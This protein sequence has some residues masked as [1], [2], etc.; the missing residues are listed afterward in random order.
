MKIKSY[1]ART[2]EAAMA[3]ARQELG[4]DAQVGYHGHNNL[5]MGVANSVLAYRAGAR[6]IDGS[7]RA[8]GA[9]AGYASAAE[10]QIG[11]WIAAPA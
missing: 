5:A 2:V 9:G 4:D 7:A 11:A 6:Q 8:L 3:T 1:F 10:I